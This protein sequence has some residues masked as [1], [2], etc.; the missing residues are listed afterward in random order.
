MIL[1]ENIFKD[2]TGR[3]QWLPGDPVSRVHKNPVNKIRANTWLFSVSAYQSWARQGLCELD[4]G[5]LCPIS[6]SYSASHCLA[7]SSPLCWMI[8][9]L[10]LMAIIIHPCALPWCEVVG[11]SL[12]LH[13]CKALVVSFSSFQTAQHMWF[14]YVPCSP[15]SLC[16]KL[17]LPCRCLD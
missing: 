6:T 4:L 16:R 14:S 13:L 5:V 9:G 15:T 12:P 1:E 3:L 17:W 10:K 2:L 7:Q 11:L 8:H